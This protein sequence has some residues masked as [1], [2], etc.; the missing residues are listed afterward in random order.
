MQGDPLNCC[1]T[2]AP[3]TYP[4]TG[5]VFRVPFCDEHRTTVDLPLGR[6]PM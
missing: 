6:P 2:V 4:F 1:S 5:Q 3:D